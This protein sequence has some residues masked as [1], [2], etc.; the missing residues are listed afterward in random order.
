MKLLKVRNAWRKECLHFFILN[1]LLLQQDL[2]FKIFFRGG[3]SGGGYNAKQN[4]TIMKNN[5][6]HDCFV[7]LWGWILRHTFS[8]AP[9]AQMKRFES[10]F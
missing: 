8:K 1:F 5:I 2:F 4:K 9:E 7:F 6:F 10:I 3:G